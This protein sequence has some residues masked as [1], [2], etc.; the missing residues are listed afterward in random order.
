VRGILSEEEIATLVSGTIE[1]GG[2]VSDKT[3]PDGS[4]SPYELNINYFDALS[5]PHEE[6]TLE[7]HLR[8]FVAAHALMLSLPGVPAFYFHSLFGSRGWKEGVQQTGQNR[9]INRQKLNRDELESQLADPT[10]QRAR[11]F[12]SLKQLIQ[13]RAAHPAFT[14]FGAVWNV[15]ECPPTI[16]ALHRQTRSGEQ[17][18]FCLQNLSSQSQTFSLSIPPT[19]LSVSAIWQDLIG[20]QRMELKPQTTLTLQPYQTLWLAPHKT[21]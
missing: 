7:L 11:V 3:N 1:R 2:L 15:V 9:T 21:E 12:N 17:R 14:P 19:L 4:A 10:S 18:L 5:N 13:A 6:E 8:R 20:K 16:F